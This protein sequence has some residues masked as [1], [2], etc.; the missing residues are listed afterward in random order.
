MESA[1]QD[2]RQIAG[3]FREGW[4]DADFDGAFIMGDK[5]PA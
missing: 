2:T 5:D 3:L 4:P 1:G